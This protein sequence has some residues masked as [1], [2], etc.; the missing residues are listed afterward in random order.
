[1]GERLTRE[2][3][4][5]GNEFQRD[6]YRTEAPRY[7]RSMGIAERWL[8]G[9]E[10]RAWACS[11]A[12][13]ATLEVAIGTG[14]NL[15]EYPPDATL[16]GIDLSSEM[17]ELARQ[18]AADLGRLV[19]LRQGDAQE[20][21][22]PD[23]TFDRVVCTY[24]LCS[25]PDEVRA[26]AEMDRVLRPG[27]LLILVDHIRSSVPPVLW[28]Q[29]LLELSPKR[30]ERELTRRPLLDVRAAGLEVL[31]SDRSRL[32]MVERLVARKAVA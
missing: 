8:F 11:Q 22:F 2:E 23:V 25:V 14:L 20:L 26:I 13:G 21:P 16:T 10:H 18:R 5:R 7:D 32:G 1:M 15:P 6:A 30:T 24:S 9:S 12:T 31:R 27:G 17:L 4:E 19:E 29:R 3:R 28:I